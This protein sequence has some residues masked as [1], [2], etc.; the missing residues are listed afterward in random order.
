MVL[1][2]MILVN[3]K[4]MIDLNFEGNFNNNIFVKHQ[5]K[6]NLVT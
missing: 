3:L 2:V 6:W 1:K 4:L 5:Q